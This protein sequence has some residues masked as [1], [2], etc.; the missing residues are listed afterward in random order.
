MNVDVPPVE[1]GPHR[2]LRLATRHQSMSGTGRLRLQEKHRRKQDKFGTGL[3]PAPP[4]EVEVEGPQHTFRS[5]R[6][7]DLRH[8]QNESDANRSWNARGRALVLLGPTDVAGV[9]MALAENACDGGGGR[10]EV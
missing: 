4:P 5:V 6:E 8:R 10:Q 3:P 9:I 7:F 1:A 2:K